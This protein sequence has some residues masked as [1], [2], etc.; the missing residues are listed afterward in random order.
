MT[1]LYLIRH[2][3]TP[4]NVEGR[5]QGQMDPE[6]TARGREQARVA[7][8]ELQKIGFAAIYS[9]DLARAHQTAQAL[10]DVTGL[11]IQKDARLREIHQGEWQGVLYTD[12]C[13]RW[14]EEIARWKRKPWSNSP[15]G[16]ESIEVLQA[17]LFAA[18]DEITARYP[19]ERIAVF[20][21]K[22]PIALL[23]IR[24]QG[25]KPEELWSLLPANAAWE[26]FEV[27]VEPPI[28]GNMPEI[29]EARYSFDKL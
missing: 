9:S 28:E 12:I 27:E 20:T 16:G 6:L 15:P 5:Y 14:P 23:K 10:A 21:H 1:S 17:R 25:H 11:P 2:G 29:G 4:W 8:E 3:E 18:I 19:N 22:L 26:L 24:Y 7:A 13:T